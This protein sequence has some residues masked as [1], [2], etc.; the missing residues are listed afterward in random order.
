M[1]RLSFI[2][3]FCALLAG[4]ALAADSTPAPAAS[5]ARPK[6]VDLGADRC[7]PCRMMTPVLAELSR[8]Y[9]GQLDVVFIDVWKTKGEAGHYGIRVIPT[10]IFFDAKG[11]ELFRHEGFYAKKG[12]LAKWRELGVNLKEPPAPIGH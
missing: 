1:K 12:I 5:P 2:S 3:L 9:A 6:L 4:S 7:V 10:Q 11:K 8:E